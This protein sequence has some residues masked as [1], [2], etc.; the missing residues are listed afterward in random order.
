MAGKEF[1]VEWSDFSGGHWFGNRDSKQP[2]NTYVGDDMIVCAAD[3]FLMPGSELTIDADGTST[4]GASSAST[5]V[6]YGYLALN[7][8]KLCYGRRGDSSSMDFVY[9][10]TL[11]NSGTLRPYAW[12]IH[13]NGKI[14]QPFNQTG[15]TLNRLGIF[16]PVALTLSVTTTL[17]G[18]EGIYAWDAWALSTSGNRIYFCAPYDPTSWNSNDYIDVGDADATI[19][20]IV[21]TVQGL[22][23]G[24]ATG[25]WQINGVL[26]QTTTKRQITTKG[27]AVAGGVDVDAGIFFMAGGNP[28]QAAVRLLSGTQTPTALW[29]PNATFN[30]VDRIVRVGGHYV[31]AVTDTT[32]VIYMWSE[33]TRNWRRI[34]APTA[35]DLGFINDI[36]QYTVASDP[37]A[38]A[39][40][41]FIAARGDVTSNY[42]RIRIYTYDIDPFNPPVS[43]GAYTHATVDLA[44]YD[45]RR[46]F[47]IDEVI[48][49]LDCGT[50]ATTATR[51]CAVTMKAGSPIVDF[52][53]D[54]AALSANAAQT[55]TYTLPTMASTAG[56]RPVV[57]FTPNE[58]GPTMSATPNVRLQGVKLRRLIM[59]C[60]EVA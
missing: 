28:D 22:L 44:P 50:T 25:W 38:G 41:A 37:G 5:P 47:T 20:T 29:D 19:Q 33:H 18:G 27:V 57:R 42:N 43:A 32:G 45:H 12:P 26:G 9:D 55:R 11:Y 6:D 36:V 1:E 52:Q 51:S 53:S 56:E 23:V 21:P 35:D 15:P 17:Y 31:F 46:P 49:E 30:G 2:N 39:T 24:T 13:F 58:A 34:Q 4:A 48:A 59:R 14:I 40:Q 54:L 8:D 7:G 3:G 60:R 10:G 16:D